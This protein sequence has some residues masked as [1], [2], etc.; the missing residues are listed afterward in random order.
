MNLAK[1]FLKV[2]FV[3]LLLAIFATAIGV[4]MYITAGHSKGVDL[5]S[6][7][8]PYYAYGVQHG[9]NNDWNWYVFA[10]SQFMYWL[11]LASLYFFFRWRIKK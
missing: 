5:V 3:A 10:I 7:L 1:K 11:L 9:A 2:F 8:V 4:P 6:F